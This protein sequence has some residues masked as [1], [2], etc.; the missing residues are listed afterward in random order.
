MVALVIVTQANLK[1]IVAVLANSNPGDQN[2]WAFTLVYPLGLDGEVRFTQPADRR[3]VG[4]GDRDD[5]RH[6]ISA[7]CGGDALAC[8]RR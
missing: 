5:N 3:S 2:L 4:V 1:Q 6:W 7:A 8:S